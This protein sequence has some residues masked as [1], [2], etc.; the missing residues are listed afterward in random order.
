MSRSTQTWRRAIA[1]TLLSS[2]LTASVIP[3]AIATPSP[4]VL[5]Q[6]SQADDWIADLLMAR[7]LDEDGEISSLV[8]QLDIDEK[9]QTSYANVVY[10]LFAKVDNR[11]TAVYTNVGARLIG[12]SAGGALL[13]PEVIPLSEIVDALDQAGIERSDWSTLE[14][15]ALAQVRY[16]T[17]D[18][19][20]QSV[21]W[22]QEAVYGQIAQSLTSQIVM[23]ASRTTTVTSRQGGTVQA[24]TVQAGTATE[25]RSDVTTLEPLLEDGFTPSN[26]LNPHRGHFNLGILQ[27]S[28]TLSEV[29]ARVSLKSKRPQSYLGERFIGDFKYS[30]NQRSQ[31]IRG[32]NPGDRVVV[33]LFDTAG[34][35]LG[36]SEFELLDDNAAVNLILSDNPWQDGLVRTVYGIDGD[37]NGTIDQS[38]AIY[39]YFTAVR[40]RSQDYRDSSVT[41]LRTT[42][43]I[44][45]QSFQVS[46]LRQLQLDCLYPSS[47]QT[48]NFALVN[49]TV[50]AFGVSGAEAI[51]AAPGSLTQITTVSSS[52][53]FVTYEVSRLLLTHQAVGFS[54]NVIV[55]SCDRD[56]VDHGDD[57]WDWDDD[58]DDDDDWGDGDD[59]DDDDDDDDGD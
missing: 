52:T 7:L 39:D 41:F 9:P 22:E 33:R 27:P 12:A 5:S 48:G 8:L 4:L 36:Y 37:R 25:T 54:D 30:I 16:D 26:Q 42:R 15:R 28:N 45:L 34:T 3:V 57:D 23:E 10:Q 1:L 21:A 46:S 29:I 56:C 24:G 14:M 20:D 38:A 40:Y 58:W 19:R 47:F 44:N 59:D 18:R 11:W 17:R 43:G 55:T 13:P 35:F 6:R 32:L 49:R 51:V 2:S 31:F 53:T 50:S